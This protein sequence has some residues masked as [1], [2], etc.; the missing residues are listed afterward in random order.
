MK[1]FKG[2][3]SDWTKK[4]LALTRER[5]RKWLLREQYSACAYCRRQISEE[6]GHH[7]V[8]HI[9]PKGLP[10]FKQFTYERMNLVACCKRCNRNKGDHNP[11]LRPLITKTILPSNGHDYLWVHPYFHR[12]SDHLQIHEGLIFEAIGDIA[13]RNRGLAVIKTCKLSTL[14]GVERRRAG[15]TA[16][17]ATKPLDA[18]MH[19]VTS[20]P[21]LETRALTTILRRRRPEFKNMQKNQ[22]SQLIDAIRQHQFSEFERLARILGLA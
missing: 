3:S 16:L 5:L 6:L 18:I 2:K 22:I 20:H 17:F 7:E 10:D 11:L 12:Y 1:Y 21:R 8:D 15:Q 14:M 9:L 13:H 19:V 4:T